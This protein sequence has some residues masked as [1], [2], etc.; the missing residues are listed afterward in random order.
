VGLTEA[1]AANSKGRPSARLGIQKKNFCSMWQTSMAT[2]GIRVA[3]VC[4]APTAA[5]I[6][7]VHPV[8]ALA[9]FAEDGFPPAQSLANL[10]R[11]PAT[12]SPLRWM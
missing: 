11:P 2:L 3:S 6:A 4:F 8:V 1:V 5:R 9:L 10:I 7:H 12:K